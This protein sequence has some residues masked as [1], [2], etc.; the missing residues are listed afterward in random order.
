VKLRDFSLLTDENIHSGV[1]AHLRQ[2]GFDVADVVERGREGTADVD[3]LRLATSEG[4]VVVTHD[5]DLGNLAIH[6][7]EP[8]VGLVF[9]RPGH[10]DPQFTVET[11]LVLLTSD[12]DL[13]PPFVLVAKRSGASVTLRV[14]H[15]GPLA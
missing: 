5:A 1:L 15:L 8:L 13:T 6:Q 4:R 10:I 3:L 11:I 9:L 14:R 12:P 7:N 2:R